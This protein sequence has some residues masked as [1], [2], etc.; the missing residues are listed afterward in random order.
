MY[1]LMDKGSLRSASEGG[2]REGLMLLYMKN[3]EKQIKK[4]NL[5]LFAWEKYDFTRFN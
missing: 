4:Y 1:W 2:N 3:E 5:S